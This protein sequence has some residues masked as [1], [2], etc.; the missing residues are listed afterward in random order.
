MKGILQTPVNQYETVFVLNANKSD[1]ELTQTVEKFKKL[2]EEY[3]K[4]ELVDIWG[5]KKLAY[6]IKNHVSGYYVLVKFS[7][8][9]E[10]LKELER[11]YRISDN[12]IRYLVVKIE[13]TKK[14]KTMREKKIAKLTKRQ[15]RSENTPVVPQE[16]MSPRKTAVNISQ[17]LSSPESIPNQS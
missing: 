4:I 17:S 6:M 3:G 7:S 8:P 10:F 13:E 2:I 12:V 1:E 5:N 11:I 15:A 9:P 16:E 14:S